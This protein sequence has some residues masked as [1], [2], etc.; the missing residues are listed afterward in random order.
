[1]PLRRQKLRVAAQQR[2]TEGGRWTYGADHRCIFHSRRRHRRFKLVYLIPGSLPVYRVT[3][4]EFSFQRFFLTCCLSLE[5]VTRVVRSCKN[6]LKCLWYLKVGLSLIGVYYDLWNT[7]PYQGCPV[8]TLTELRVTS[9]RNTVEMGF[10]QNQEH[11][12]W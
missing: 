6:L 12:N 2:D 1:M 7:I 5:A 9:N 8:R 3:L 4:A 10:S 11:H